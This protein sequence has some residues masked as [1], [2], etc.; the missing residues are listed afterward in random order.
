MAQNSL[1]VRILEADYRRVLQH[2]FP[3]DNDEH[4]TIL[5]C[6]VCRSDRGT[7]LLVRRAVIAA[8]AVDFVESRRGYREFSA[9]FVAKWATYC[10]R[11]G[12]AYL[13]VHNHGSD[14]RVDFSRND[15]E[16][17]A[18]A[19]PSLQGLIK[20]KP[21]GALV[22][23]RRSAAGRVLIDGKFQEMAKMTVVGSRVLDL[24]SHPAKRP[25]GLDD[26]MYDR[27][28][29]LF[30]NAGQAILQGL[31]VGFIGLGGGGSL[32][33]E[34]ISRL[35]VGQT[36]PVDPDIIKKHNRP[37]IVGSLISDVRTKRPKVEVAKRVAKQ[38]NPGINCEP[39]FDDVVFEDVAARLRDCD[40]IFLAGDT[41]ASRQVFNRVVHQ[42]LIPGF[43]VG[44]RVAVDEETG[45]VTSVRSEYRVVMPNAKGGCLDCCGLVP[46]EKLRLETLSDD[47]KR[48]QDYL[49][50][51]ALDELAE[52]SVI[53][54]NVLS[55][56]QAVNDFLM[57]FTGLFDGSVKLDSQ[58]H[59]L[60]TRRLYT[61][62][63]ISRSKCPV[64]SGTEVSA[65]A[66]GDEVR[67]PCKIRPIQ[68]RPLRARAR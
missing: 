1:I 20:G 37:R 65:L 49:G 42:Y 4:G 27:Q 29:R 51:E 68:E 43:H 46:Q 25:K 23:G 44:A 19:Y 55:G 61:V 11:H 36:V 18:R 47:Q 58:R 28:F 9:R 60:T 13:A 8:E 22:F 62:G 52:P 16:S 3:G 64:C 35:G 32:L 6:G 59:E 7:R 54:L 48:A 14:E 66:M 21:V 30:G 33:N 53:T 17:H 67:L 41:Y 50:V 2:L 63:H 40:A 56:A 24:Y 38:A 45:A 34:W 15:L 12:L 26:G 57:M 10:A 31:K 5:I 39:I